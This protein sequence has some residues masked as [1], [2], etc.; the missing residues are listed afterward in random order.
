MNFNFKKALACITVLGVLCFAGC[1]AKAEDGTNGAAQNPGGVSSGI[2][3]TDND[4][5]VAAVFNDEEM[6]T[7]RDRE[8]S[9]DTATAVLISAEAGKLTSSSK[10]VSISGGV[11]TVTEE[12]TYI[13]SGTLSDGQ[14]IVNAD[15]TAKIQL[16]LNGADF[17][18]LSSAP[19]YVK[20]AD[21][22]FI[23][24]AE[25]SNNTLKTAGAFVP[26]GEINV[27]G[28]IFSKCDLT[29]NGNGKLTVATSYGHGIVT[30]DDLVITSGEYNI[31]SSGHA[32]SGKDSI[33]AADG[34]VTLN[35][36]K[37]GLHSENSENS[38]K[39][40]IYISGGE[41]NITAEGDGVDASNQILIS[42][43][44]LNIIAG[45]GSENAE[46]K[47]EQLGFGGR[48]GQFNPNNT[49]A[50][51]DASVS[52]KGIKSDGGLTV[53]GGEINI[54]SADDGLHCAGSLIFS[55]GTVKIK[56]GDDG[57]HSDSELVISGGKLTVAESYE[58]IEGN[59]IDILG[60]EISV[61]AS[62]DGINAAGGNDQSGAGGMFG[63]DPFST[64]GSSYIKIAG[65]VL[66]VNASG[67]GIDSNG[68]L[69]VEGGEIYVSGPT[70]SGNGALD[71]NGTAIISGGVVVATG[72]TGM[73]QNFSQGSTQGAMLVN[74][75]TSSGT[76]KL[77]DSD[78][79]VLAEYTPEKQYQCAVI[80]HPDIKQGETYNVITSVGTQSVTMSSLIYGSGGMGGSGGMQDG[81]HGGKPGRW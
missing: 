41:F 49:A 13:L 1:G 55:S 22:V 5:T 48:P 69:T 8:V 62:D 79:R 27:D 70:N 54:N 58:G 61:T 40:F 44:K 19:I 77:T 71:Y 37:D 16:V 21:K 3:A 42:G 43:G 26:D 80:S 51:A 34:K 50:S 67:D 36:Q 38:E 76:I 64:G 29:L 52:C 65:G 75:G 39:G 45:G 53:S 60:G 68:N 31:T 25:G 74:V 30:K 63:G 24:L 11:A 7:E 78:G 14:I 23:T 81:G 10:S 17:T 2:A 28:V 32:L 18:S 47:S 56:T 57:L 73:A 35:S 12:G 46:K 72:S 59:T 15:E 66:R 20:S 9:Y 6:F 4:L 33:R